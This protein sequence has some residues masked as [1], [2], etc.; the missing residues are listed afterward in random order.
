M[1]FRCCSCNKEWAIPNEKL[2][3]IS[4][5]PDECSYCG[6]TD[7]NCVIAEKQHRLLAS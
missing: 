4:D 3:Y 7:I 2:V 1:K 5:W 6:S